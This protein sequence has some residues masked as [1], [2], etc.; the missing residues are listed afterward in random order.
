MKKQ[1]KK[2]LASSLAVGVVAVTGAT[3]T[4]MAQEPTTVT[5]TPTTYFWGNTVT[6]DKTIYEVGE[7]INATCNLNE[8]YHGHHWF[9]GDQFMHS[10][11]STFS[12]VANGV[13][14]MTIRCTKT[15]IGEATYGSATVQVKANE[16][17]YN[18]TKGGSVSVASETLTSI[19]QNP[20]GS[21]ATP[22]EGYYFVGWTDSTGAL[23]SN[24]SNYVPTSRFSNTY[25]AN[26]AALAA[27]SVTI[28]YVD[29]EE[30]V[31]TQVYTSEPGMPGQEI[32]VRIPLEI[33]E[34]YVTI[35]DV[36][37]VESIVAFGASSVVTVEVEKE[38]APVAPEEEPEEPSDSTPEE[39][40]ETKKESKKTEGTDTGVVMSITGVTGT[41]A[42]AA[43]G[44][45][46]LLKK[47]H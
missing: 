17:I 23:V 44:M 29:G 47:R 28:N 6:T 37:T 20:K 14:E 1:I 10:Y 46:A 32:T 35:E 18:A 41:M 8:W 9:I 38:K 34:G 25:T 45:I 22:A 15:I 16:I 42:I 24:D 43:A 19:D 27:A 12:T 13:G 31:G 40:E 7:T 4:V 21:I 11:D 5:E 30:V 3:S 26:F 39:T 2:L 33:P 36:D